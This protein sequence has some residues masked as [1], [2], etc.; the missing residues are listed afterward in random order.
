LSNGLL[1]KF[2]MA[3]TD[4]TRTDHWKQ[5]KPHAPYLAM[6][7]VGRFEIIEDYWRDMPVLFMQKK[8]ILKKPKGFI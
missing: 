8:K 5:D 7:A 6:I 3:N 4:G 2:T 1:I